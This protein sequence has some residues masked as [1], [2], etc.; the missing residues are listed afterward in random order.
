MQ[1][2]GRRAGTLAAAGLSGRQAGKQCN[3]AKC[4]VCLHSECGQRRAPQKSWGRHSAANSH[5][6]PRQPGG[7]N[8]RNNRKSSQDQYDS[9]TGLNI[10][11]QY[12]GTFLAGHLL[13]FDEARETLPYSS[14]KNGGHS[15]ARVARGPCPSCLCSGMN[16]G[17]RKRRRTEDGGLYLRRHL[18]REGR[19]ESEREERLTRPG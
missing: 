7:F 3:N 2:A 18:I 16:L 11:F 10:I 14:S 8:P 13:P 9:R 1:T 12:V 4:Q 17:H 15:R 5:F 6:L 19:N